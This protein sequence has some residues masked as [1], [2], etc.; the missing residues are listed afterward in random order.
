V[1]VLTGV[2]I[3]HDSSAERVWRG[4]PPHDEP[5]ARRR[6]ERML[7]AK[8]EEAPAERGHPRGRLPRAVVHLDPAGRVLPK[9]E[10]G[11]HHVGGAQGAVAVGEDVAAGDLA[12]LDPHQVDGHALAGRGALH[13]AVVD[14]D[15]AHPRLQPTRK[16]GDDIAAP[17]RAGPQRPGDHGARA[18]DRERPIYVQAHQGV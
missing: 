8:L 7:E 10:R 11:V 9:V 4:D 2:R 12:H 14:L 3:E 16:Q 17:D 18:L 6:D 15:P 5:V 13:R 1:A